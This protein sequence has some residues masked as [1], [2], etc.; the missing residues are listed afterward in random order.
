VTDYPEVVRPL[1]ELQPAHAFFVGIDSDG[2]VFDTMEIKHKECFIPNIIKFWGL[3]PV[4]RFAREAGEFVN[5]YSKWRGVNRWPALIKVLDL[6]RERPEVQRRGVQVPLAPRVREFIASG[7]PLSNGSLA[8]LVAET[9]N[10][11]LAKAL[12]W[13]EAVN[14]AIADMVYGVAPFSFVRESLARIATQADAIVVSQTPGEALVR[15]WQEH[16]VDRYVLAIAGQELGAKGEHLRYASAGKYADDHKLMI[17][18]APGDL[19][20][21]RQNNALFFPV[22]PGH[23]EESWQRF[24]EEAWE[25][26][27]SGTY[28]GAYEASLIAE[29]EKA[30]PETPPW[31]R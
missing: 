21:A 19:S 3:Q 15:E 23:E 10:P 28:G 30:L 9:D 1:V 27:L 4:S 13:S 26:F 5:L 12:A 18:D 24:Y 14:A 8:Q 20:A 22:N 31:Q 16:D 2:C 25:R 6:L 11:E 7:L 29:F 17:G